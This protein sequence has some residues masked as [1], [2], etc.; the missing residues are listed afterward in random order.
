MR[1]PW[2]N[3]WG[4]QKESNEFEVEEPQ[5]QIEGTNPSEM[6]ITEIAS[7]DCPAEASPHFSGP[8]VGG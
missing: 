6:D 7:A 1:S 2:E 8:E 4:L 3:S 5:E